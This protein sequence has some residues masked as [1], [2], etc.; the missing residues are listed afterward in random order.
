[1][2]RAKAIAATAV[3]FMG[4]SLSTALAQG[5]GE[6][7]KIQD[8][9][10]IGNMIYRVAVAKGYCGEHGI[11]CQLQTIPSGPLGAQALLAKSIDV[12][13][14]PPDVQIM[15]ALKGAR[16]VAI[17]SGVQ[18]NPFQIVA[19][20]DA[21]AP[22]AGRDYRSFMTDLKGKKIGVPARGSAGELQ[23]VQLALRAGLKPTDF[24]FV[25]VGAPVTA[26]GALIS[27]QVDANMTFE[28]SGSMCEVLKTC[29][30]LFRASNATEP[31]EVAGTNGGSAVH[32]MTSDAATRSPHVVEALIAAGRDAEAFI[33]NP[34]NF[35]E[36]LKIA[37][38]FF[39]FDLPRGDEIMTVSLKEAIPSYRLPISRPALKQ[40]ADNMLATRQIEAA[41]DTTSLLYEKAP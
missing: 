26:Y 40:V 35:E 6:T 27:K 34:A 14:I 24:T 36:L 17:L 20:N 18:R 37:Q 2:T 4:I 29:R 32:A 7:V 25:A 23:F 16:L 11:T 41:F 12:A 22:A 1:M 39:K 31:P 9:P 38:G 3:A 5:R 15:A 30:T 19:R 8:Y 33:Q 13:L 28:P 21:E 10:G